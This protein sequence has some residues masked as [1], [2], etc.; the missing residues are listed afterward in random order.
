MNGDEEI[1][2]LLKED[3][4]VSKESLQI[5]RGIRRANRISAFFKFVYWLIVLAIAF[6]A[7]YYLQPFIDKVPGL[8]D[9]VQGVQ[10]LL[11]NVP[12]PK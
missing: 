9:Q 4:E 11:Q 5:L 10:K 7:Y 8:L 2:Q 12:T 1:K 3:V 6:G